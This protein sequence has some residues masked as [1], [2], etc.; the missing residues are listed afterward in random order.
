MRKALFLSVILLSIVAV[1]TIT[2]NG[3][4]RTKT[5]I[6]AQQLQAPPSGG[7]D[8]NYRYSGGT[9]FNWYT[10]QTEYQMTAYCTQ[11]LFTGIHE[12][13][14]STPPSYY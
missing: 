5:P 12:K 10:G 13:W 6:A 9:R 11:G 14:T 1:S 2:S 8:C 4:S 7:S 3:Q